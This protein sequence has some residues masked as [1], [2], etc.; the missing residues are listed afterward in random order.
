MAKNIFLIL[1]IFLSFK[2]YA[3]NE[4][5]ETVS[6]LKDEFSSSLLKTNDVFYYTGN[7]DKFLIDKSPMIPHQFYECIFSEEPYEIIT[8]RV[9]FNPPRPYGSEGVSEKQYIATWVLLNRRLYLCRV[10]LHGERKNDEFLYPLMEKLTGNTFSK[11]NISKVDIPV[12]V[13]GLMSAT[14]FTDTLFVKK[15]NPLENPIPADE[16]KVK[17]IKG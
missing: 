5:S 3:Q 13:Y 6:F 4:R 10:D 15:A 8:Y 12:K 17:H 1:C 11:K 7:H 9:N 14:W 2:L 16:W